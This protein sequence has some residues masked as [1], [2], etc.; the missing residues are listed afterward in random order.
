[1]HDFILKNGIIYFSTLNYNGLYTY[2]LKNEKLNFIAHF[3]NERIDKR[4]IHGATVCVNQKVYFIPMNGCYIGV[5][6][7]K[8]NKVYNI[9]LNKI[10]QEI[11]SKFYGAIVRENKI[12]LIPCRV[13]YIVEID[14]ITEEITYYEEWFKLLNL[15]K[16]C[17]EM[18][19]KNAF[20]IIN[21]KLYLGFLL[22]SFLIEISLIDYSVKKIEIEGM[23]GFVD[24]SYDEDKNQ[25]WLLRY[26]SNEILSYNISNKKTETYNFIEKTAIENIEIPYISIV[27][28]GDCI[29]IL[30]YQGN[31][32]IAFDKIHH[33]GCYVDWDKS[34][35]KNENF[36][37]GAKHYFAKK[38]NKQQ[39][40]VANTEDYSFQIIENNKE[41][42]KIILE[43]EIA[44]LRIKIL[45]KFMSE[46]KL[47]IENDIRELEI[48]LNGINDYDKKNNIRNQDIMYGREIYKI[49][50]MKCV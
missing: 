15:E 36:E 33:R 14:V 4:H 11:Y 28:I 6:D 30:S 17:N 1:M 44:L 31:N 22:K 9:A 13:H 42:K 29:Y 38:L 20:Y 7:I 39:F 50:K 46:Q 18:L 16:D 48:F 19:V 24:L 40:I 49:L 37:W 5:Y 43:D 21:E 27:D 41:I 35:V 3:P 12:I 10:P 47:F 8:K 25:I 45:K 2:D 26:K 23:G 32:T 34:N